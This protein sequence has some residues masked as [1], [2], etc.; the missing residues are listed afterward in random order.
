MTLL[1]H[2]MTLPLVYI[3]K[4]NVHDTPTEIDLSIPQQ[5]DKLSTNL[6]LPR[7][8]QKQ[9]ERINCRQ[10]CKREPLAR[11]PVLN[12]FLAVAQFSG[13]VEGTTD[14]SPAESGMA[15]VG[16]VAEFFMFSH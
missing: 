14:I 8:K 11:I 9:E 4:F 1:S 16:P 12:L 3:S 7:R 6:P 15:F 10:G 5:I 2:F 13:F